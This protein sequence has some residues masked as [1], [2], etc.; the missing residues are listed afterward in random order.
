MCHY[1]A[2]HVLRFILAL[3]LHQSHLGQKSFVHILNTSISHRH[4]Q[5]SEMGHRVFIWPGEVLKRNIFLAFVRY[6][7]C[8]SELFF[9]SVFLFSFLKDDLGYT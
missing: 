5:F 4:G 3:V 6:K 7:K 1:A 8:F 2:C 9:F